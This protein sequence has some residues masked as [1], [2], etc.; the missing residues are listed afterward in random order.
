[1]SKLERL[2]K[3]TATLLHTS[4]PLSAEEIQRRVEGYPKEL[5]A[6]RRAFERDKDDLREM[7]VPISI[8]TVPVIDPP[9]DGYRI[10]AQDYYL[11]DPGLEP[12]EMAAITLAAQLVQFEGASTEEALWKL[13][14]SD[15][16]ATARGE[17]AAVATDPSVSLLLDAVRDRATAT[18]EYGG[19]ERVLEPWR[20]SHQKGR[21][22][23]AGYDRARKDERNF[24]VDRIV[25]DVMIGAGAAFVRP[26]S[27][28]GSDLKPWTFDESEEIT[29]R[30]R[31]DADQAAWAVHQLGKDSVV[32]TLDDGA[33]ECDIR[34]S[35]FD[36]FR[37]FVL[38]FLDHAEVLSPPEVRENMV[39]WLT[40]IA[41]G[42]SQ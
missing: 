32:A 29:A 37:S 40:S 41:D 8:E 25:G 1:M 13:G 16:H 10:K 21:W 26:E 24:R 33:V 18:F 36:A 6:F 30:V 20:L 15:G 3:L 2:M 19:V 34:V 22:Y 28:V 17:L 7:G 12:D 14:G 35:N 38:S 9:V 42:V 27:V 11:K 5:V 4:R 39:A 31:F 23:V